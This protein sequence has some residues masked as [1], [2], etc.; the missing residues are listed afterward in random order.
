MASSGGH[1]EDLEVRGPDSKEKNRDKES[2]RDRDRKRVIAWITYQTDGIDLTQPTGAMMNLYVNC[3]KSKGTLSVYALSKPITKG[4]D[5]VDW[6]D[7]VYDVQKPLGT[8]ALA[9]TD[10]EKMV[11]IDLGKAIKSPFYGVVLA[12]QDGLYASFGSKES[13]LQPIVSLRYPF[14]GSVDIAQVTAATAKAVDAAAA[15]AASADVAYKNAQ[16]ANAAADDA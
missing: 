8:L 6:K 13:F 11:H 9:T 3:L 15:A 1:S 12:S 14:G 5:E 2:N 4:E 7:I 16:S 10:V